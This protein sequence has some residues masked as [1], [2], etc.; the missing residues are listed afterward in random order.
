MTTLLT[1]AKIKQVLELQR[2][3]PPE[4]EAVVEFMKDGVR[5]TVRPVS[6][7]AIGAPDSGARKLAL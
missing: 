2:Q 5:V 7:P 6:A 4:C 3:L 1:T